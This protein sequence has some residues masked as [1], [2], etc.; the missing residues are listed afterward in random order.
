[1]LR[2]ITAALVGL[3]L[4]GSGA[5]GGGATNRPL[6]GLIKI[7][8][9]LPLSGFDAADGL[10]TLY[11]AQ[12]AVKQAGKVCGFPQHRDV[13]F[14]L[15]DFPLDDSA[16]EVHDPLI[17]AANVSRFVQDPQ[18]LGMIGPLNQSVAKKQ[19]PLANQAGLAIVSPLSG[20]ECLTQE[21]ADGHCEGLAG[22]LRPTGINNFFRVVS[23]ENVQGAAGADFSYHQLGRRKAYVLND[24]SPVAVSIA[25]SFASRFQKNGGVLLNPPDLGGFDPKSTDFTPHLRAAKAAQ[26]DLIYFAGLTSSTGG[27]LRRQMRAALPGAAFMGTSSLSDDQF[28]RAAGSNA[29]DSYFTLVGAYP[30]KL[31]GTRKFIQDY[32][33]E[34]G[35]EASPY[36]AQAF[37]AAGILIDAIGRAIDSAG[38]NAPIREQVVQQLAQT[39]DYPG[40]LGKTSFTPEGDTTLKIVTVYKWISGLD[41]S[42]TYVDQLVM[43]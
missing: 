33:A 41:V 11:G 40:I 39:R 9:D 19:I 14:K 7:G 23:A 13:C 22:K 2:R 31:N 15:A 27:T 10:P 42:G 21:A 38:G 18:V 1:M 35:Q 8:I 30:S 37:E 6:S 12:L 5:G 36:A 29:S 32:R 17:G 43:Q 20:S 3:A 26:A 4:A 16:H 24:R 28:A 34:Y 25:R